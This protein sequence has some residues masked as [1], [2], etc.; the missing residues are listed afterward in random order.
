MSILTQWFNRIEAEK[1]NNEYYI[2]DFDIQINTCCVICNVA[3]IIIDDGIV[4][5]K[6][7]NGWTTATFI[8]EEI[9]RINYN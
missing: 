6:M 7:D 9:D 5:F 3:K 4:I 1:N 2:G 8:E